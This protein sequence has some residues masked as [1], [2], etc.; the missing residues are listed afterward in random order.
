MSR[1]ARYA[2]IT[3]YRPYIKVIMD[4]LGLTDKVEIDFIFGTW[5][6]K[7]G[8]AKLYDGKPSK[9]DG[10]YQGRVRIDKYGNHAWILEALMHELKHIQQY[11]TGRLSWNVT[12]KT[13]VSKRG[14]YTSV[15]YRKWDGKLTR[16]YKLMPNKSGNPNPEY[17]NN[18]WEI[19]ARDYEQESNRLRL[20]PNNELPKAKTERIL[21]GKVGGVTFYKIAS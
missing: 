6:R 8:D 2:T 15:P 20:F 19:D 7:G 13:E 1:K 3:K 9:Y 18:P 16:Q 21:V 5:K 4:D 11:V 10:K 14:K 12:W 17:L